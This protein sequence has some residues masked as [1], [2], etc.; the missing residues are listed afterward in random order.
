MATVN[1][2]F[3]VPTEHVAPVRQYLD[4]LYGDAI[5]GMTDA[6]AFEHHVVQAT[7][8]GYKSW[9]R[10]NDAPVATAKATLEANNAT[11]ASA[12]ATDQAGLAS[13]QTSAD[14]AGTSAMAG[15]S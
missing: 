11:R 14:A 12:L 6:R 7:V 3:N 5:D 2:S 1:L 8:P 13:A 15:L 4:S 9:R 10:A